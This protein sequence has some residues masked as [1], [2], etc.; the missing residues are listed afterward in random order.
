[1]SATVHQ[2]PDVPPAFEVDPDFEL[3]EHALWH[4]QLDPEQLYADC[5]AIPFSVFPASVDED[6]DDGIWDYDDDPGC[7][8]CGG[9][10]WAEVDDPLWD[11]CDEFGYG[12]C[13]ACNGTGQRRH[14]WVF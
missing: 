9:E 6:D 4:L 11:E 10:G 13:A 7:T 8:W 12:P 1:M 3:E 2:V 14:Q 5:A